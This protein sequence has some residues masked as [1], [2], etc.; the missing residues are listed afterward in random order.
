MNIGNTNHELTVLQ[1]AEA[2]VRDI[3][4][5]SSPIVFEALPT[6]DP[7]EQQ[8]DISKATKVSWLEARGLVVFVVVVVVVLRA[9]CGW[10]LCQALLRAAVDRWEYRFVAVGCAKRLVGRGGRLAGAWRAQLLSPN[11]VNCTARDAGT[12]RLRL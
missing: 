4:G 11:M 12:H 10:F 1:L 6:D 8:P 3:T 9:W 2:C 7:Q 5:S